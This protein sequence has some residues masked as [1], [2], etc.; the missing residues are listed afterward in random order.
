MICPECFQTIDKI[1][2][3]CGIHFDEQEYQVYDLQNYM[4]RIKRCYSRL[5][6]FKEVLNQYQGKEG[7][8]IPNNVVQQIKDRIEN[9][10]S[11]IKQALRDL[12]MTKY[13]ENAN[14]LEFVI[15][16]K[17]LPYIPKLIE[18]KLIRF[19]KMIDRAFNSLYNDKQSFMSYYYVIYKLLE[20]MGEDELMKDVPLLKTKMRLKSHDKIW[21]SICNELGWGFVPTVISAREFND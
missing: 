5:D 12:K 11:T 3:E 8:D 17:P 13:V 14:Y 21:L 16:G 9:K 10:P 4:P 7:R 18:E 19:F 6:H 2:N 20:M 15:N 1:C